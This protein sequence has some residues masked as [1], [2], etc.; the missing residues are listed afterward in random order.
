MK[1]ERMLAITILLLNK[2]KMHPSAL[3]EH[4]DVSIRTIYRDIDVMG[5]AG[6]PLFFKKGKGG[7]YEL[8]TQFRRD[9]LFMSVEQLHAIIHALRSVQPAID[10]KYVGRFMERVKE[11]IHLSNLNIPL[12]IPAEPLDDLNP[13]TPIHPDFRKMNM[14][15][16]ATTH[17]HLVRMQYTDMQGTKSVRTIEPMSLVLNGYEWYIR[18]FCR[19]RLGHRIFFVSRIDEI[20]L[21]DEKFNPRIEPLYENE[22]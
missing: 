21:M 12:T 7:G 22:A 8:G 13:W 18:A 10:V 6:I 11:M 15:R 19:L 5:Q 9:H 17:H 14:L 20:S 1:L 2:G 16:Q 3:A 4:F